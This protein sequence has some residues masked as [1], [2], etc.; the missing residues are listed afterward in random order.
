MTR[1]VRH[2]V[3][4]DTHFHEGGHKNN[5]YLVCTYLRCGP[6]RIRGR[7]PLDHSAPELV[8]YIC[9]RVPLRKLFT[10]KRP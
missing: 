7:S 8:Q 5:E 2:A 9:W 3:S 10:R 1:L 6:E 4:F